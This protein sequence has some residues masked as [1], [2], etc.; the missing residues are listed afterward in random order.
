MPSRWVI[1]LRGPVGALVPLTAPLAVVSAWLDDEPCAGSRSEGSLGRSRSPHSAPARSWALTPPV[2]SDGGLVALRVHLLDD[3]LSDRLTGTVVPGQ[4]VRL[5]QARYRIAGPPRQVEHL[6]WGALPRST[7]EGAWQ[8]RFVSPAT[9]RSGR[10]TSPW[11]DPVTVARGLAARWAALPTAPDPVPAPTPG[12]VWVSDVEGRS[13]TV[14]LR[15]TVVSGFVGRVRY[16]CDGSAADAA[17]FGAL[18]AF[19]RYAGVGSHTTAG[20]G[21]IEPEPTWQPRR[22]SV[23]GPIGDPT[24]GPGAGRSDGVVCLDPEQATA[25]R[26]QS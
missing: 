19:G 16:V 12:S 3:S 6:S 17:A 11:P 25:G 21:A 13:E 10:R 23:S 5:G 22:R 18:M 7:G 15:G 9:F 4:A 20:F 14:Q 2:A 24:G 8:V 1:S 26:A